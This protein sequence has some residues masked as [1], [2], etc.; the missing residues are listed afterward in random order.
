MT[1]RIATIALLGASDVQDRNCRD[2][3]LLMA[4]TLQIGKASRV[5]TMA[6]GYEGQGSPTWIAD[7]HYVRMAGQRPDIALLSFFADGSVPLCPSL[8]A[9]LVNMYAAV[10][11]IQAARSDTQIFLM[12]M[13]RMTAARE[14][15][16]FANLQ[17][18]Y[19]QYAT[20]AANRSNVSVLD[21]YTASGDPAS[22]PTEWDVADDIHP[23]L[24][25]HERLSIPM[26]VAALTSLVD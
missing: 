1:D 7:G 4:K 17:G 3:P 16:T 10:D 24:P 19:G 12:K 20:V 22:H 11:A 14:A 23:L 21:F 5:R 15:A 13:W 26:T 18:V 6:F 8:G 2:W 25:W 9:N